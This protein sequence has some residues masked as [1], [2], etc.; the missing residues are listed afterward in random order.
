MMSAFWMFL[1]RPVVKIVATAA[2]S[3][4]AG[5]ALSRYGTN[6]SS[7]LV[8]KDVLATMSDEDKKKRIDVAKANI[9]SRKEAKKAAETKP[10]ET[11]PAETKAAS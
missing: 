1:K 6:R 5:Y 8:G 7:I 3:M 11:K 2:A 9:K 4:A 10:A